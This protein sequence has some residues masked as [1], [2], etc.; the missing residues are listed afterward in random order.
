MLRAFGAEGIRARLRDHVAL[1]AELAGWIEAEPGWTRVAPQPFSTVAFRW[2]PAGVGPEALDTA[3]RRILERVNAS[4]SAFLSDTRLGGRITL[5][6]A[7]GNLRTTRA[8]VRAARDALREVA[9][10]ERT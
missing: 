6:M 3:N 2:S 10:E 4:G 9:S 8:H 5:R 1:A 7:I